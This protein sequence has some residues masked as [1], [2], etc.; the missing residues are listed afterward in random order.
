M[1]L[2]TVKAI[3]VKHKPHLKERFNVR[4]IGIFGSFARG[5]QKKKSDIDILVTFY[6]PI[7]LDFIDLIDYLEEILGKKVDLVTPGGLRQELKPTI[8]HDVVYA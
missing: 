2:E 6:Q 7:G 3:L 1:D 8:M 4:E 5:E